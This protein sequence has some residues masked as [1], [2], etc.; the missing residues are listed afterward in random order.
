MLKQAT[1]PEHL[2][3][4]L[5]A[6]QVRTIQHS[7]IHAAKAK[8]DKV[9][10]ANN[11]SAKRGRFRRMAITVGLADEVMRQK[12]EVA[13][14]EQHNEKMQS[15][16]ERVEVLVPG[17]TTTNEAVQAQQ[18]TGLQ[19]HG[20]GYGTMTT[21]SF[22]DQQSSNDCHATGSA[23]YEPGSNALNIMLP[24]LT[25]LFGSPLSQQPKTG[26]ASSSQANP[27]TA[28]QTTA[29]QSFALALPTSSSPA[30][31]Q[32]SAPAPAIPPLDRSFL[33]E[34]HDMRLQLIDAVRGN[35]LRALEFSCHEEIDAVVQRGRSIRALLG[36]ADDDW[37]KWVAAPTTA[38]RRKR[39]VS[40]VE[41]EEEEMEGAGKKKGK[42][43]AGRR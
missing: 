35:K 15:E 5:T 38:G 18:S 7:R 41:E 42:K 39:A 26:E 11:R 17:L 33:R 16:L 30:A 2:P 13:R 19:Q 25:D 20:D 12:A 22:F 37:D 31:Q 8:F 1:D 34:A 36:M 4:N 3:P 40:E 14:L 10:A 9:R 6:E 28:T 23:S 24:P 32:P 27:S 21:S 43:V 29:A